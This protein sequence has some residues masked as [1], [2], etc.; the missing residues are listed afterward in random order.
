[1]SDGQRSVVEKAANI[2][3]SNPTAN[4]EQSQRDSVAQ[5]VLDAL[6]RQQTFLK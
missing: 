2:D 1:M 5:Q 6:G 3:S 4:P